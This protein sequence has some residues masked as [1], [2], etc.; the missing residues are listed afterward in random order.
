MKPCCLYCAKRLAWVCDTKYTTDETKPPRVCGVRRYAYAD[1]A[2]NT[3]NCRSVKFDSTDEGWKC[4]DIDCR[5]VHEGRRKIVSRTRR[6]RAPGP[7][8]DGLFCSKTHGWKFGI[9]AARTGYRL[10]PTS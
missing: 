7:N 6:Y 8:G 5:A 3:F 1:G 2:R 9:L 10:K 4:S